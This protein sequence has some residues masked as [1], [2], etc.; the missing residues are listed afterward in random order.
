MV[1]GAARSKAQLTPERREAWVQALSE[2][3]TLPLD[4]EIEKVRER[5]ASC[6]EVCGKSEKEE[7]EQRGRR[8]TVHHLSYEK[9]V[10]EANDLLLVCSSCHRRIH[11]DSTWKNDRFQKVARSVGDLLRSLGAD[12]EDE[13]FIETPRRVAAYLLEHFI[14]E[15]EIEEQLEGC[16]AAVFPSP[17]ENMVMLRDST[18]HG[19]CPHHLLPVSYIVTIAY[20]PAGK[21]IGLSKLHRVADIFAGRPLLQEHA[22]T[23]IADVLQEMLLTENVAVLLRGKHSCMHVRGVEV[24]DCTDVATAELRGSFRYDERVR[25]EFYALAQS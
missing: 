1:E 15:V 23:L 11:N 22:T 9:L 10:P 2:A 3:K 13:N 4:P 14:P 5:A 20:I 21:T 17:Y 25:S 18:V 8:L 24:P 16:S 6:C 19:M 12:L 7:K